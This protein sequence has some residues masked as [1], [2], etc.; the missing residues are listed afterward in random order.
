MEYDKASL[1]K[2]KALI[3]QYKND[4]T[5]LQELMAQ[6]QAGTDPT[7]TEIITPTKSKTTTEVV[8]T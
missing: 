1:A 3:T 7:V 4:Q 5:K 2:M 6:I 8:A